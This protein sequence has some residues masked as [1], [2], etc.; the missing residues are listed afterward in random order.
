LIPQKETSTLGHKITL[1]SMTHVLPHM[2]TCVKPCP[3]LTKKNSKF[4]APLISLGCNNGFLYIYNLNKNVLIKKTLL[5]TTNPVTGIEWINMNTLIAWSSH[6][7][8]SSSTTSTNHQ[9][10]SF[11]NTGVKQNNI[12]NELIYHDLRTGKI[13]TN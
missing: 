9:E 3:A 2:P 10:A 8:I 1:V 12:K 5:F 11:N 4:W 13:K 6:N 7:F